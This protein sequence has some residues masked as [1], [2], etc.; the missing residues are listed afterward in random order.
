MDINLDGLRLDGLTREIVEIE[1]LM[2]HA[3]R[4]LGGPAACQ[5]DPETFGIMRASQ[6]MV[7]PDETRV[8]YLNDLV[9][10][11]TSGRNLM[12]EKYARMMRVTFPDE[13]RRLHNLLPRIGEE[14]ERLIDKLAAQSV[15][16][17]EEFARE[18]PFLAAK[19]RTIAAE[20]SARNVSLET[21]C[22]GECSTYSLFT[23]RSL[24]EFYE[25]AARDGTNVHMLVERNTVRFYGY[26]SLEDAE[27]K[28]TA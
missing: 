27:R 22:R 28:Q 16:W 2:F 23:L 1:W 8:S 6:A 25:K 18:Y 7:W 19:G 12:V 15:L 26:S 5:R 24:R 11:A 10:A 14:E 17:A 4:N 13:Y 3:A 21:Y 20:T 9:T